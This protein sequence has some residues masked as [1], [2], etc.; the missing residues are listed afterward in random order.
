M[1]AIL[2]AIINFFSLRLRSRASL[3][4][5]V[6]A[7]RHQLKILKPYRKRT[8]VPERE[9]LLWILLYRIWPD[10]KRFMLIVQPRTVVRWHREG[11][12]LYWRWK[13]RC[14]PGVPPRLDIH[15]LARR[16]RAE[17]PLWGVRRIHAEILKL[18]I[19][20]SWGTIYRAV[21]GNV[22]PI[23]PGWKVFFR[24]HL[25]ETVASDMFVVVSKSYR[26]LYVLIFLELKRR[27]IIH[28]N[29][30]YHPTQHW[31]ADQLSD[32]FEPSPL[33]RIKK[34][35]YLLRDRDASYGVVFRD[36]LKGLGIEDRATNFRSPW[37]NIYVE[38]VIQTIRIECLNHVIALNE[39]HLTG[40]L[41]DYIAYYNNS[42]PHTSL[43]Q[44]APEH[45]PIQPRCLGRKIVAI[46]QVG[47]LHHR[48]ERRAA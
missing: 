36:R 1:H 26:L 6:I 20:V 48:Y 8:R 16:L 12:K 23:P 24:N 22:K 25:H 41:K 35:R 14:K 31:L 29:V 34:P 32:A 28:F 30:T 40:I 3:E 37:Q 27:R 44:D 46:P 10:V 11:F 13:S 15:D 21:R 9:R 18:G 47:G 42:R 45:R 17:N 4:L 38:R 19:K 5:E 39:R 33:K 7:L 2:C 43:L